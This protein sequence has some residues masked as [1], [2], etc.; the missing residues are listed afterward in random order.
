MKQ[1]ASAKS[2]A[3]LPTD[4]PAVSIV[5]EDCALADAVATSIANRIR[6]AKDIEPAIDAGAKIPG[7]KGIVIVLGK[8]AGFW[9]DI[10]LTQIR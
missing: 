10:H 7:V 3:F 4:A 5:A 2:P 6:K 8:A 9:G 1:E